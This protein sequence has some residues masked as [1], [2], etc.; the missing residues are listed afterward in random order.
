M[1][2]FLKLILLCLV[3]AVSVSAQTARDYFNE[4]K[5]ANTFNRYQDEFVC[6][7]DDDVP[8]FV[9]IAKISDVIE[10][11]KKAGNTDDIKTML[12]AK[13]SL[14]VQTYY[15]GVASDE[16]IYEP[17]KKQVADDV[18]RDYSLEFKGPKP[19]KMVYSINWTTDRYLLRVYIFEQSRT[20]P[21]SEGSGRCELIHPKQQ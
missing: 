9:V 3:S 5:A 7:R 20:I 17:V 12:Q 15:K 4:L 1:R 13:D 19:S 21:A 2:H 14:L 11:M 10:D 18:N 8:T 16:Y 6:F